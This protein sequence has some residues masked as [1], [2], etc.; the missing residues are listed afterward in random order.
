MFYYSI[1]GIINQY[2]AIVFPMFH[3]TLI[4]LRET[5]EKTLAYYYNEA[6]NT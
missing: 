1:K 4:L 3:D 6:R 2:L 5:V